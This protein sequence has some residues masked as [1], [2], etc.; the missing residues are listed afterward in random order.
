MS[1][2]SNQHN[3]GFGDL[4]RLSTRIFTVKPTRTLL[5]ILGTS[6]GIATVVFLISLGYGLQYILLGKLITT[7]DSLVTLQATY[8]D[9]ANIT[10]TPEEVSNI[11]KMS[12]VAEVSPMAEFTAEINNGLGSVVKIV[13][14]N[15]F[16]LAGV[17][18]NIGKSFNNENKGL[19]ITSMALRTIGLEPTLENL[20]KT[21]TVKVEYQ[22]TEGIPI[23]T[24]TTDPVPI[25]G[26]IADDN[27]APVAYLPSSY[28]SEPPP[29]YKEVFV[30]A[31]S[32]ESVEELRDTL[33]SKGMI[34][35]ARIDLVNQAQ[36]ILTIITIILGVFGVAALT[37]SAVG[38]FNTMIVSFLERTYE[39]GVMKSLGAMD[40]DVRNLFLMESAIM[41]L[42]GGVSGILLG[43]GMGELFNLGLNLLARRLGGESINLFYTPTWFIILV[44]VS[45]SFIGLFAGFWPA[46]RASGLSP[47]EA[48]LRK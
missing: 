18:P 12:N 28:L 47:K 7:Q 9:E 4:L 26:I 42:S 25:I 35:S 32:L 17:V 34:I 14:T 45:S 29:Y 2:E 46:R 39:V 1:D 11:S 43:I 5:T 31:A 37:V 33:I 48:F 3:L 22:D 13:D 27:E 23:G 19:V 41:G 40:S 30:K 8:P 16:R 6:I 36:K 15:Y 10:L 38:M 21:A 24:V 44:L 20:N